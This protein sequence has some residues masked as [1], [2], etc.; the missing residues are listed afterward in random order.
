MSFLTLSHKILKI[1]TKEFIIAYN[2]KWNVPN[3]MVHT[4][5]TTDLSRSWEKMPTAFRVTVSKLYVTFRSTTSQP[6][7][8]WP[9]CPG[10]KITRYWTHT[11]THT[12][13][14]AETHKNKYTD[15]D[16]LGFTPSKQWPAC[17]RGHYLHNTQQTQC[18]CSYRFCKPAIRGTKL[19]QMCSSERKASRF[20]V[21]T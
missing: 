10:S 20:D 8:R 18:I 14:R 9:L 12:R 7:A 16:T 11:H 13:A 5:E 19:L 15:T 21:A 4:T 17:R 6:K 3:K 1:T 2:I